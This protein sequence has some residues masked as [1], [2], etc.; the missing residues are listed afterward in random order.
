[1]LKRFL[2][3]EIGQASASWL[4]ATVIRFIGWST[5][6]E[7]L[8]RDIHDP[9]MADPSGKI[10]VFWHNR[11]ML[12]TE[13]WKRDEPMTMLQSPHPD[14]RMIARA[15]QRL[16]FKTVWG[17]SGRGKDK[18]GAAGLRELARVLKEGGTVGITPDGP[19][20]PRMRLNPGVILLARMTGA[21][22]VPVTWN[23][24]HRKLLGTWDRFIVARPFSRGVIRFGEPIAVPRDATPEEMERYRL[25][26]ESRLTEI[27]DEVDR[28]FGHTPIEPAPA[29]KASTEA[30]TDAETKAGTRADET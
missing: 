17:T 2:R 10:G 23:V 4:I 22:I 21:E 3:S 20:G 19:R 8:R 18:G 13:L 5:R 30:D 28:H 16:G 6:W 26:V 9:I 25:L 27:C 11:I 24:S 7:I 15:I 12:N 14:G 29:G 1:M